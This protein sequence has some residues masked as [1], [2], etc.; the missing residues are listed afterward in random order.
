MHPKPVTTFV[1]NIEE[2]KLQDIYDRTYTKVQGLDS[3]IKILILYI[4]IVVFLYIVSSNVSFGSFQI[5][6]ISITDISVLSKLFPVIFSYLMFEL[7]TTTAHRSEVNSTLNFIFFKLNKHEIGE[8][9]NKEA[10]S[11]IF[12]PYTTWNEALRINTSGKLG[13]VF[14]GILILL[15]I[16][17]IIILPLY[18]EYLLLKDLFT[19]YFDDTFGKLSFCLSVWLTIISVWYFIFLMKINIKQTKENK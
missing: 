3:R 11:R 1:E 12:L 13:C 2:S 16:F 19:N 8:R 15:P 9:E 17:S 7:V 18:F 14:F 6:P 4:V 5:G 10:L